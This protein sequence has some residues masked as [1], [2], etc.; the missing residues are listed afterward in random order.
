MLSRRRG[1]R[2]AML[3]LDSATVG[4]LVQCVSDSRET[5]VSLALNGRRGERCV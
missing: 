5:V 3:F 4:K 1:L 2:P